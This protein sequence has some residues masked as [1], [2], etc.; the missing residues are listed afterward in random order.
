MILSENG[1][2]ISVECEIDCAYSDARSLISRYR[3]YVNPQLFPDLDKDFIFLH[4]TPAVNYIELD[5]WL[6]HEK[7]VGSLQAMGKVRIGCSDHSSYI[8]CYVDYMPGMGQIIAGMTVKK[9][10]TKI[11]VAIKD[12]NERRCEESVMMFF[13][14]RSFMEIS[15]TCANN[16]DYL[17]M[18]NLNN[19]YNDYKEKQNEKKYFISDSAADGNCGDG[20]GSK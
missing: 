1:W 10:I 19:A 4:K 12:E 18:I 6:F 11:N 20:D 7:A 2:R 15:D 3:N 14:H 17:K 8:E 9:K 16:T 5:N 13:G